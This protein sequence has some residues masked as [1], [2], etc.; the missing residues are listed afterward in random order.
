MK[1][2]V[3]PEDTIARIMELVEEIEGVPLQ[4]Q[5]LVFGANQLVHDKT[6]EHDNSIKKSGSVI[7]S[8]SALIRG[9]WARI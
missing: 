1:I 2:A 3:E 5:R 4:E 9:A 8:R 6:V 7:T